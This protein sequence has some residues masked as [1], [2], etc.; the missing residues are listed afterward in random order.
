MEGSTTWITLRNGQPG[1]DLRLWLQGTQTLELIFISSVH[2]YSLFACFFFNCVHDISLTVTHSDFFLN[3]ILLLLQKK[4]KYLSFYTRASY[5]NSYL[6]I[7][8]AALSYFWWLSSFFFHMCRWERRVDP[9]GRVY[10]VDHITRTTTWQR[11]TQESVRNYEEWQHQRSQLQGAMQQFN[12]RFIYGVRAVTVM[13]MISVANGLGS[14]TTIKSCFWSVL[15]GVI[16]KV[17]VYSLFL[18]NWN[19]TQSLSAARPVGGNS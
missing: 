3:N 19:V 6:H 15:H 7:L 8:V 4:S 12:Q 14:L 2:G 17:W 5:N 11:P 1:T 16:W 13:V 9:M 18:Y 10:Y